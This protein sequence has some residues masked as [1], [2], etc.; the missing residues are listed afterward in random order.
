MRNLSVDGER[1]WA[2]LMEMA[3]IGATPKG[4]NRRLALS[5]LDRDGRDRFVRW[6]RE[7]GCTIRVDRMGNIF[8]RRAGRD[9][10]QPPVMIGS[11]LDTQPNGGKFDGKPTFRSRSPYGPTRRARASPRR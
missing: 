8:A 7:A 1:L 10:R 5:D 9:D 3:A 2:S 6:C 11:H 4:G